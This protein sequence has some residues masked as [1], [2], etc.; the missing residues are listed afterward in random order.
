MKQAL[1][2][3]VL[4]IPVFFIKQFPY[5]EIGLIEKRKYQKDEAWDASYAI[6]TPKRI[7]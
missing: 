3:F 5:A 7:S 6:G 4:T 1:D 2:R